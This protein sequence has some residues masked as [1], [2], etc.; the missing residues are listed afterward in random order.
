MAVFPVVGDP[1]L[2]PVGRLLVVAGR[3]DIMAAVVAVIAG[4]PYVSLPRRWA[5][6]L[7]HWRGWPD[8]N[9][10][11]RKRCRR[12]Q[13]KSEQQCQCNFLHEIQ[14]LQG[15]GACELPRRFQVL[16]K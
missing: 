13:G 6:P 7:V 15:L 9:Y 8:A 2:T 11:L 12:D 16:R 3:P 1:A 14:I 10:D 5:A 4:L